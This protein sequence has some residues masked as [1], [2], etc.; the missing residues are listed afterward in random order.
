MLRVVSF[1]KLLS[2]ILFLIILVLVYA[3][4][5][6]MVAMEPGTGGL[7]LHKETF[8]YYVVAGFVIV[9]LVMLAFQKLFEGKIENED[10]KAWV[11]SGA[12]VINICLTL[13]VGFI[14]VLN[15]S[16]HLNPSG[17]AYLNYMGPVLIFSWILGLFYLIYKK[18]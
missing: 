9:N 13:L 6:I 10:V 14:G 4:L 5:P 12:F 3:Y 1:L 16:G 11:R 17:F 7:Q 15:N 18:A 2:I 8:F